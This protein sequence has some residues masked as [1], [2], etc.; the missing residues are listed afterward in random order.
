[1]LAA[2]Q[3]VR[4]RDAGHESIVERPA[5][6][7]EHSICELSGMR[8]GAACPLRRREWLPPASSP[9]PCDWHHH[10]EE[11]LLTLWPEPYRPWAVAN[12]L[13]SERNAARAFPETESEVRL[14]STRPAA[15][16]AAHAAPRDDTST[17]P[18]E[19]LSPAEGATYLIDPTLRPDFQR[20]AL[21]ASA[22][23]GRVEWRIDG[24]IVDS[25]DAGTAE[26]TL[27]RGVHRVSARDAL[28]RSAEVGITVK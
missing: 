23:R 21:R 25:G 26:W 10:S 2:Q 12:R 28:G 22:G 19:I 5:D 3:H 15:A 14:V 8:A 6:L 1:M 9:L 4:G 16:R 11:G 7:A 18:L 27:A 17:P 13:L 24:R 20:L